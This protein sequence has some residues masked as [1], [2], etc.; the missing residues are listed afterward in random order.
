MFRGN[1]RWTRGS[2]AASSQ[3]RWRMNRP[4]VGQFH[5]NAHLLCSATM[6]YTTPIGEWIQ[7]NTVN[8]SQAVENSTHKGHA[9]KGLVCITNTRMKADFGSSTE[10][11]V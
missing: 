8:R 5:G 11:H 10:V 3:Y 7:P 1:R 6:P 9:G 4:M 2:M